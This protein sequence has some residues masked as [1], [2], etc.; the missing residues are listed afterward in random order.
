MLKDHNIAILGF[1]T[2]G[3]GVYEIIKNS[4]LETLE[5]VGVK[6]IF[7]REEK[8]DAL[9]KQYKDVEFTSDIDDIVNDEDIDIVVECLGGVDKAYEC[10]KKT[11]IQGKEFI[12]S[13]KAL[14]SFK[15][16]ELKDLSN[17][18]Y[19]MLCYEASVG[20]GTHIFHSIFDIKKVDNIISFV[21]I[22]NGTSN[23]IL[24][25]MTQD[26]KEFDEV[27]KEAQ[28]LRYAEKD[29]SDDIDGVDAKYKSL[30]LNNY[31][32]DKSYDLDQ[33]INF[34]IRYIK[35]KDIMFA[36][37]INK[38][39]KLISVGDRDNLFVIPMFI[40]NSDYFAHVDGNSN[41]LEIN[42]D[43]LGKSTYMAEGA[44]K[45]PTAHSVVLD[46]VDVINGDIKYSNDYENATIKNDYNSQFYIRGL[47]INQFDDIKQES[48]DDETIITKEINI[49]TLY[50]K[51]KNIKN[52][53]VAK[54]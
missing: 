25:K 45:L 9:K 53:F 38:T 5:E 11:L 24:S 35:K 4:N 27:L 49:K 10:A 36:S 50:E 16:N 23:Y 18:T 52:I 47:A 41:A 15:F 12:T 30:I 6:K 7:V 31:I 14:I 42:S 17:K 37:L 40:D 48:I 34:G 3:S 21:A 29:P 1:G 28:A 32:F 26:G 20:G 2:V 39:I 8:I 33:I 22:I 44:G 43:N 46:I 51:L 19:S 13:N 54:I